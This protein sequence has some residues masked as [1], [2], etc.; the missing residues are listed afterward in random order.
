MGCQSSAI[1]NQFVVH[2]EDGSFTVEKDTSEDSFRRGFLEKN[3]E[4]IKHVDRDVRIQIKQN[5][6]SSEDDVSV[7]DQTQWHID[8]INARSL[9]Q[10]GITG[11]N[12]IVG[13]VDGYVDS[14][15]IQL[16]N[17][18]IYFRQFNEEGTDIFRNRHG[19]H[20]AGLVAADPN[21]GPA[22]G[23][24]PNAK[25]VAAQFINNDGSG[26]IGNSILAITAVANQGAQI[27]N[28]SWGGAP[29]VENLKTLIK[30]LSDK[31]I[32]IV[33]AAGNE[34]TDSDLYP[35]YPAAF[36]FLNQINVAASTVNDFLTDFSNQGIQTVHVAAPGQ[37]IYSTIPGNSI[38]AM[39][40]TSMSAPIV[41]GAAALLK[42]AVP[43]ATAQQVKQALL[44][45]VRIPG[46]PLPVSSGGRIDVQIALEEL[47][48]LVLK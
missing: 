5:F 39:D 20:V 25:I 28:L 2:W 43:E 8:K 16:K 3:L 37:S 40:G 34:S 10:K 44:N 7:F 1:E 26:S 38:Q 33:T 22:A 18:V 36:K 45:S 32:I 42:S 27:I 13:I 23:V 24:A 19:T 14:Q 30:S 15:H 4:K 41:S 21:L 6:S 9:W 29:C 35:T 12:V 46:Q 31:G 48:R 17:N 47:K 11:N